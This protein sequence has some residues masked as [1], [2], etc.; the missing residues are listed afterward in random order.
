[1]EAQAWELQGIL[2]CE[3]QDALNCLR[4]ADGNMEVAMNRLLDRSGSAGAPT[5]QDPSAPNATADAKA[6]SLAL[7]SS[8][9]GARTDMD[10]PSWQ[11]PDTQD[12]DLQRA[13]AAS[14]EEQTRPKSFAD[15][16]EDMMR[17]LAQSVHDQVPS[18]GLVR[19]DLLRLRT[20]GPVALVPSV[21]VYR[22]TSLFL[23][24]L[25]A[26]P[27]ALDAFLSYS[28]PNNRIED[29]ERYWAGASPQG[30]SL[31]EGPSSVRPHVD[32]IAL[33]ASRNVPLYVQLTSYA[34]AVVRA[35]QGARAWEA[36]HITQATRSA[37]DAARAQFIDSKQTLFQTYTA[38]A[39]DAPMPELACPQGQ[40]TTTITLEH[41]ALEH[42]VPA[43]L[44]RTLAAREMMDSLLITQPADVLM[45]NVQ[46]L[47]AQQ[48]FRIDPVIYLDPFLWLQRQGHRI[49]G[50][51]ECRQLQQW[52]M[53]LGALETKLKI[54]IEPT[55]SPI[56]PL[57]EQASDYYAGQDH[58][59]HSWVQ[60]IQQQ[61]QRQVADIRM[62]QQALQS[63]IQDARQHLAALA[64]QAAQ[65][66]S[67]QTVPYDLCAAIFSSKEADCVYVRYEESWWRIENGTVA[68]CDI[69]TCVADT[70]GMDDGLGLRLST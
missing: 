55:A 29:L 36:E 68:P 1:M 18:A 9:P 25:L 12:E 44:W 15:E 69:A 51:D 60:R 39:C 50:T 56:E 32:R 47:G 45:L 43:C 11:G 40:P 16:D 46:R 23:Q 27:P 62:Q 33:Q 58:V 8:T 17:A 67:L 70:R 24:A 52:A 20:G 64:E 7:V 5:S 54:L 63:R 48:M 3:Y 10:P 34:E 49:D 14:M 41:T 66:A 21:P 59:M 61:V 22:V 42:S 4:E 65:D 26:S 37:T 13:C 6:N 57:L 38:T 30:P 31:C 2:Q 19:P 53:E 28:R 35:W